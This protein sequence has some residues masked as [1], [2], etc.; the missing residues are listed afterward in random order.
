MKKVNNH[1][2]KKKS[3]E[4]VDPKKHLGQ[5][6]LIDMNIATNIVEALTNHKSYTHLLEIGAG[7][8]VLTTSLMKRE[9]FFVVEID[10][11][12][13]VFLKKKYPTLAL[14]EA[15]FL[16]TEP[17]DWFQ[18]ENFN[19]KFGV[20][21]NFPYHI[22]TQI[23][24]KLLPYKNQVMEVVGMLQKEVAMR[25]AAKP[26]TKDYG[27][28][29]VFLQA[30]YHIEY[31]FTVE[32]DAFDPPPKVRSGVIRLTRNEVEKL[33]C[34]ETKLMQIVKQGF[35]QR[36]KTLR[37]ALKGLQMNEKVLQSHYLD[38]RAEELSV[39]DY[40]IL[41]NLWED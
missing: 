30:Y 27:I 28:L 31:L 9:N 39:D 3:S 25:L 33:D 19:E 5:H 22:S 12:S 23:F 4:K 20:I 2:N 35:N 1:K 36:R 6:F 14:L 29:S 41:T 32:P 21:S 38:K 16:E 37:N 34:N 17:T 40:V 15:D 7:T 8:G 18:Q 24:F 11:E 26:K 13:V 10:T